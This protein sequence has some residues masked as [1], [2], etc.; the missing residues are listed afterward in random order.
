M[1]SMTGFGVGEARLDASGA[2]GRLAIEI[3]GVNHR[4]LDLRVKGPSELPD[5]TSIVESLARERLVRG[6]FDIT[7]RVEGAALGAVSL[8]RDRARSVFKALSG[9]RD[10]L[11]PNAEVPLA[12]LGSVPDLFVPVL[13]KHGDALAKALQTAFDLARAS[14]DEMRLREG[15]SLADDLTRRLVTIRKTSATVATRAPLVVETYRKRLQERAERLRAASDLDLDAGR[16]EQE[17]A[18]YA[19]RIDIAEE[20]TRLEGH[21][22][23]FETL[24]QTEGAVGRRLDFLLQEMAREA[25]TIGSKSQDLTVAH[26]VVELKAEIERMREQVQNAE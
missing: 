11:A 26:A 22:V 10:E 6:R 12:L 18:L 24:L 13:E 3:R 15:Q 4:F 25:N 19:D 23:H 7:I 2:S 9:L 21:A 16:L 1:R 14:L 8:D 20:L 5:V 17:V